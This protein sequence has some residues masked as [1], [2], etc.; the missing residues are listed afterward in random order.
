MK[1]SIVTINWNNKEGLEKTIR[2]VINQSYSDLEYIVIDGGSNDGSIEIINKYSDK[3]TFWSS[4]PDK[5]IYNAMN[6]G[7][8]KAR[9]V[10]VLFLNSGDYLANDQV[11][12]TLMRDV[13]DEDVIYG[14]IGVYQNGNIKEILSASHVYY[15]IKYQ[16]DLPPHP[17][18]FIKGA[19]LRQ[20]GGF[21]EGYKI[22]ADVVLISKVFSSANIKYNHFNGLVT[23][24]DL[25][26]ISSKGDNQK[27]IYEERKRFI[28]NEFPHYINDFEK[29]YS[30]S[31]LKRMLTKL[32][33]AIFK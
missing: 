12:E 17:A 33:G 32:K 15:N 18:T 2:S 4:E 11:I 16:H 31:K 13:Q 10:Y 5:G 9:G 27:K 25:H 23:I 20:Y 3:I 24:F 19:L 29:I 14:N 26:G 8:A 22:I 1:V 21:D 7:L 28:I 6:K 30:N